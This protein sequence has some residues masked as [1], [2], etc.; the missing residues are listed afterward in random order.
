MHDPEGRFAWPD[1]TI[2]EKFANLSPII[3][4]Y[5]GMRKCGEL[6]QKSRGYEH[7]YRL[8]TSFEQ[9]AERLEQ[10]EE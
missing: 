6:P 9:F 7:V 4:G 10:Q 2:Y 3:K 1:E 8:A 5:L